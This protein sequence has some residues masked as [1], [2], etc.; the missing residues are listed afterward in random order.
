METEIKDIKKDVELL[1]KAILEIKERM[2]F[3]P[4]ANPKYIR[5]LIK[6]SNGKHTEFKNIEDLRRQIEK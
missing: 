2:G 6:I 3:E 4:E 5:K 1:K